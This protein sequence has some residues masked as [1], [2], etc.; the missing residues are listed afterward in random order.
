ML[1]LDHQRTR[2]LEFC[3]HLPVLLVAAAAYE[4]HPHALLFYVLRL[5]IEARKQFLAGRAGGMD[6]QHQQP[7]ANHGLQVNRPIETLSLE[8]RRFAPDGDANSRAL[9]QRAGATRRSAA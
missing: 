3:N 9:P 6:E 4:H 5:S 2:E 7:F 1:L 8:E